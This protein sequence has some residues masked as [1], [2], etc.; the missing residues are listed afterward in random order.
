[1]EITTPDVK[2]K[3]ITEETKIYRTVLR[4]LQTGGDL[5]ITA[6]TNLIK[7]KD[8]GKIKTERHPLGSKTCSCGSFKVY[9]LCC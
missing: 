2:Q 4:K 6:S 7:I 5:I 8:L 1:M 9:K 3:K